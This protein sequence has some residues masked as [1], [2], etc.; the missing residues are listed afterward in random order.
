VIRFKAGREVKCGEYLRDELKKL[1]KV[2]P[3]KPRD[4]A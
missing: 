4:A 3:E 2:K 1:E